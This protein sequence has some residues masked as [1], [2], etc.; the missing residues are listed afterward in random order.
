LIDEIIGLR[1]RIHKDEFRFVLTPDHW[2]VL[3]MPESV[4]KHNLVTV[5]RNGELKGYAAFILVNLGQ[6]RVYDVREIVAEDAEILAQLIDQIVVKGATDNVD[7]VFARRCEDSYKKVYEEKGALSFLESVM[8]IVLLNPGE[9]LSALSQELV[10]GKV[11]RL[12]IKGFDPVTVKVGTKGIRV[13]K[14]E[15]PDLTVSTDSKT[16]VRLFFGRTSF[17]NEFL[18]R[19]IFLSDILNW[20]TANRFFSLVKH[21]KLYIPMGDWV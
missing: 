4:E 18:R 2:N 12:L 19:K 17:L 5:S 3:Y 15:N 20:A 16:F 6:S 21:D 14:D 1:N 13:V 10:D 8:M 9:L 7:F 11:L